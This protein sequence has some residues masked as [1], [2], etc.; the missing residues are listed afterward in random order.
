M[1]CY[2]CFGGAYCLHLQG[3]GRGRIFFFTCLEDRGSKLLKNFGKLPI[4]MAS[5]PRRLQS[6][7]FNL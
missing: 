3:S 2:R 5:Y 7:S 1:I 4:H 6:F